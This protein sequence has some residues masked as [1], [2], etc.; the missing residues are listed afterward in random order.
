[1]DMKEKRQTSI[2]SWAP[3]DRPRE[4]MLLKGRS[5]LSDAELLAVLM[6][7]GNI[8]ES[9]LDLAKRILSDYDND[10]SKLSKVSL[11]RF[12]TYQ[13]VGE[14]KAVSIVAALELGRRRRESK[15]KKVNSIVNSRDVFEY[16]QSV[17]SDLQHEEFWAIFLNVKN[18]IIARAL[19]G[20]GGT[21]QTLVDPKKIFRLAMDHNAVNIIVSHNH[22]SGEVTPSV[23]DISLTDKIRDGAKLLDM[24]L[25]DHIIVG[26]NN[27]FSFADEGKM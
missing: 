11:E 7:S 23:S 3:E 10:L 9:A 27:Y 21:T 4:K 1:M 15:V 17:L 25:L 16:M 12:M 5:A 13:G 22:P 8:K 6:G 24:K 26:M 19:I 20:E 2:K 18:Q 14:A